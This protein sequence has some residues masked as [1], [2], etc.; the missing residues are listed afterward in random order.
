MLHFTSENGLPQN[1]VKAIASDEDGFIWLTTEGGLVRFDGNKFLV[2][3]K[4]NMAVSSNRMRY[5]LRGMRSGDLYVVAEDDQVI[6]IQEGRVRP[7]PLYHKA[8]SKFPLGQ[9]DSLYAYRSIGLPD[10]F[11]PEL[12]LKGY[13]IPLSAAAYFLLSPDAV[14]LYHKKKEIWQVP[15]K[16]SGFR[17]FFTLNKS[18]YH[19]NR[20]GIFTSIRQDSLT[21]MRLEGDILKDPVYLKNALPQLYWNI[22]SNDVFI[23]LNKR[24]YLLEQAEGGSLTTRLLL[25]G[26]DFPVNNIHSAYYDHRNQRLFLGSYTRGLFVFNRKRFRALRAGDING[27]DEN[28]YAQVPFGD[29][30][31]LTSKGNILRLNGSLGKLPQMENY[32]DG[33]S[34]LMGEGGTIWT[35]K[36][37]SVYMLSPQG[38]RLLRRIELP[39]SVTHISQGLNGQVWAGTKTGGLFRINPGENK[40]EQVFT[41]M[42]GITDLLQQS[43]EVLWAGTEA[44]LYKLTIPESR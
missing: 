26:F 13:Q 41:G 31:V 37:K 32:S 1:S 7:L 21:E 27:G 23:Y 36:G 2:F 14:R 20:R 5:I 22:L 12:A 33:Y 35:K 4:S 43:P 18:L 38:Q 6:R 9:G 24:F 44:G 34:L 11:W 28:Y 42:P 10:L 8:Y 16:S 25:W 40:A 3:N 19:L 29:N 30:A 39:A 15:Y 17:G